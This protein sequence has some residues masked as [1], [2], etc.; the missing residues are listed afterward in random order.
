MQRARVF[1]ASEG[2]F[3]P[4]WPHSLCKLGVP[5][6]LVLMLVLLGYS[7][8]S[9]HFGEGLSFMFTPDFS[10]LSWDS[11]LAAMGQAFFTLSIG[12]GAIM[13]YGAYLPEETSIM[14][15]STLFSR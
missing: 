1:T 12:M 8:T 5:A 10:K 3:E 4:A 11:V 14:G 9:G 7:I 15:A 2:V 13:A 6:L